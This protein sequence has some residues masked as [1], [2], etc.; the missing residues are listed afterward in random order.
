MINEELAAIKTLLQKAEFLSRQT[1]R[2]VEVRQEDH[3]KAILA[4]TMVTVIFL[5]LSFVTSFLGM[6]TVD[7]RDIASSQALFWAIAVPLTIT[8]I[9]VTLFIGFKGD[10]LREMI[11][12]LLTRNYNPTQ[13]QQTGQRSIE[14]AE[15]DKMNDTASA[16]GPNSSK[17]RRGWPE[18]EDKST[19]TNQSGNL[20]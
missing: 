19:S 10:T 6:N 11:V 2:G 14:Y 1:Q 3:G 13:G 16:S 12:E 4:F 8:M 9:T 15:G 20:V 17:K 7:I 5:P 18:R